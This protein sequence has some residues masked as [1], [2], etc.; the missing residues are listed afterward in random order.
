M[1]IFPKG[2]AIGKIIMK[3]VK[4]FP[5]WHELPKKKPKRKLSCWIICPDFRVKAPKVISE[6]MT[7]KDHLL[8]IEIYS[9][10]REEAKRALDYMINCGKEEIEA[11][12]KRFWLH[13]TGHSMVH[14]GLFWVRLTYIF[15]V[16]QL[17][18][19]SQKEVK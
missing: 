11:G 12:N 18:D 13:A 5:I 15:R 17:P 16:R 7:K 9:E 19:K 4:G 6:E 14:K 8:T 2:T 10:T 1:Q 3:R